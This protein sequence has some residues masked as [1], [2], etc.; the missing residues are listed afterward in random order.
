MMNNIMVTRYK[1]LLG[2]EMEGEENVE[3]LGAIRIEKPGF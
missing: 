1:G 2:R 3:D